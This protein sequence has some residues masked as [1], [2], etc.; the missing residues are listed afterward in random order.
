MRRIELWSADKTVHPD[1]DATSFNG[2]AYKEWFRVNLIPSPEINIRLNVLQRA[3]TDL[4]EGRERIAQGEKQ[5]AKLRDYKDALAWIMSIGPEHTYSFNH[6]CS[7]ILLTD[8][9][10]V[11]TRVLT[12]GWKPG[13]RGL[14][15]GRTV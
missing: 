7:E 5:P 1:E 2:T 10:R 11:R 3:L 9:I 6:I 4:L 14:E 8:P 12:P 13:V 15:V